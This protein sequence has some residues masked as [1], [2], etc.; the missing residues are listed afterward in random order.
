MRRTPVYIAC[1]PRPGVGKT[2]IARLLT[3]FQKLQKGAVTAFDINLREPSLLDYQPRHTETAEISDTHGQMVLM[4]RLIVND[5]IPK[6]VDLGF[7]AFDDF[8]KMIDEIGFMKEADRRNVD[9]IVLFIPDATRPSSQAWTMLRTTFPRR[10]LIPVNNEHVLWGETL[11]MFTEVRSL[12]VAA[13]PAFLKSIVGRTTFSFTD[14]L[15]ST[16]D[17]SSELHQ[18]IR[19][20]YL[21]FR[22]IELNLMLHKL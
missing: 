22:E 10:A 14:Y 20:N 2:L 17:N 6:I 13:L 5:G 8:F 7:H 18:W 4:D 1:S 15:R 3:E 11:P 12:K 9:P 21:H 16:K 19:A